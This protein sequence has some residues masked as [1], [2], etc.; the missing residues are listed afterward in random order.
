MTLSRCLHGC[1]RGGVRSVS[2]RPSALVL[3]SCRFHFEL[4]NYRETDGKTLDLTQI[5]GISSAVLDICIDAVSL[6]GCSK[7]SPGKSLMVLACHW[8][9]TLPVEMLS[10]VYGHLGGVLIR[11]TV[12]VLAKVGKSFWQKLLAK[13]AKKE[14]RIEAVSRILL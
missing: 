5:I 3:N 9:P 6:V 13:V 14:K 2:S 8:T 4:T 12:L 7:C 11:M 1:T 10:Y